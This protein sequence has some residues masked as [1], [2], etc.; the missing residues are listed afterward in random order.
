M[1]LRVFA[2]WKKRYDEGRQ[3]IK[4]QRH[5]FA[6]KGPSSQSYLTRWSKVVMYGCESWTIKKAE[7]RRIDA[8][9]LWCWRRL[10]KSLGLQGDPTSPSQRNQCWIF[11]GRSDAEAETPILWPP[12][13]KNWLIWK[14]SNA[15]KDWRQVEK[16][17]T[18]DEIVGWHHRQ[19]GPEFE[20]TPGDSEG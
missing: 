9:D 11:T 3:H 6:N 15:G 12:D 20:Q 14:D 5:Y 8:F 1:K 10:W 16:G 18:R 17:M 19:N 4:K 13:V 7:R 2:P